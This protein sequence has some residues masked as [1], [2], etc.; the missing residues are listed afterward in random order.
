MSVEI[1]KT[2][3]EAENIENFERSLWP[4][5]VEGAK[6]MVAAARESLEFGK[7]SLTVKEVEETQEFLGKLDEEIIE[8]ESQYNAGGD[9]KELGEKI[10]RVTRLGEKIYQAIINYAEGKRKLNDALAGNTRYT[11]PFK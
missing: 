10:G 9:L 5:R 7:T 2:D 6:R 8:I 11:V 4:N 1:R 3:R